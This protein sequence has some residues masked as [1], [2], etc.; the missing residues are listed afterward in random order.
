MSI[1]FLHRDPFSF[2]A[3]PLQFINPQ[4]GF[5][6]TRL[7]KCAESLVPVR[8]DEDCKTL[9][10]MRLAHKMAAEQCEDAEMKL[11]CLDIRWRMTNCHRADL[12][13]P[14]G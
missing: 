3:V 14:R 12:E 1:I 8:N 6:N 10:Y 7:A 13:Y 11:R 4:I 5:L 9:L 2:S